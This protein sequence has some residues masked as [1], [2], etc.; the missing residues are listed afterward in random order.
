MERRDFLKTALAA[1]VPLAVDQFIGTTNTAA[2]AAD[3]QTPAQPAESAISTTGEMIYR[4]LGRTG[5]KV[6]LLG[7]GGSYRAAMG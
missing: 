5:E 2:L 4:P 3:F 7:L 6:S 1:A